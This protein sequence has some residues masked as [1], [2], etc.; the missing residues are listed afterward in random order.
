MQ[1]PKN[2]LKRKHLEIIPYA[3]VVGSLMYAQ[4]WTRLV[5]RFVVS[6]QG[7]RHSNLGMDHWKATKKVLRCL[8][9]TKDHMFTYRRTYHPEVIRYSDLDFFNYVDTRKSTIGYVYL[10]DG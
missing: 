7:R 9:G 1:C 2:D 8:Q 10:L 3:F 6:M 4:T 5:I